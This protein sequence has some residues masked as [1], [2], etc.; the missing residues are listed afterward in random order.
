[1]KSNDQQPPTREKIFARVAGGEISSAEGARLFKDSLVHA[2]GGTFFYHTAWEKTG[3]VARPLDPSHLDKKFLV[4]DQQGDIREALTGILKENKI[5]VDQRLALVTFGSRFKEKGLL[6]Y[7]VRPGQKEDYVKLLIHLEKAGFLPQ[8]LLHG[9]SQAGGPGEEGELSRD[10]Y[11][12]YA[13]IKAQFETG[14]KSLKRLLFLFNEPAGP[15]PRLES[16]S[17]Y[18]RSLRNVD[19]EMFFSLV[20]AVLPGKETRAG[21]PGILSQELA[22]PDGNWDY[23]IRYEQGIRQVRRVKSLEIPQRRES[24]LKPGG[25]YLVTGGGGGLG[26]L[27][28]RY[29]AGKYKAR[30]VLTGRS[31]VDEKCR[32][33]L[34]E[35]EGLGA[36]VTYIPA[37][38]SDEPAMSRVIETAGKQFGRLDGVIHSAG[39]AREN[40]IRDK[41]AAE[42]QD[43]LRPKIQGTI[44]LDRITAGLDLDFFV[45]FSSSSATL[46]DFGQCD[47]AVAN[48][49]MEAFA[50]W[51]EGQRGRNRRRG[52]SLAIGWPMWRAG[53]MHGTP[54]SEALYLKSSGLEYLERETGIEAFENMLA[55]PY[56]QVMVLTGNRERIARFWQPAAASPL[57]ETGQVPGQGRPAPIDRSSIEVRLLSDIRATAAKILRIDP[58]KLECD[59]NLGNYGF[60]SMGLKELAILL[61]KTY[62]VAISPTLFFQQSSLQNFS[63]YLLEEFGGEIERYYTRI[64]DTAGP[65]P[66]TP[67]PHL[68]PRTPETKK[69]LPQKKP[70]IAV[71]GIGCRFPGAAIPGEFWHNL[72]TGRDSISEVPLERWDW[73]DYYGQ[74]KEGEKPVSVSKWAGFIADVDKFDARF[75]NISPREAELMDPQQRIILETVFQTLG[76]AGYRPDDLSGRSVGV[77]I[78]AESND[79]QYLLEGVELSPQMGIGNHHAVLS[80]RISYLL[81]LR[82]AS[83]TINTACSSSLVAVCQAVRAIQSGDCEM[84]IAGGVSLILSPLNMVGTSMIGILSPAGRCYTFDRRANGYVKGEGAGVVFLKALDRAVADHDHIYGVIKG[85]AINHGG[86]AN[87]LT[88]PNSRAQA[89]LVVAA[90]DD[91]DIDPGTVT[92]IETHGTATEL[93]DPVEVEGLKRAFSES[94]GHYPQTVRRTAFCGLGTVKTNIGHLEAASGIAGMIKV[95]LAMKHRILPGILHFRELNPYIDLD[96]SPFYIHT[97]TRHWQTLSDSQGRP[98]PRRSGVSSFGFGGTNAHVVLE[99]YPQPAPQEPAENL[100]QAILL[101]A[102]NEERLKEYAQILL[103]F[104]EAAATPAGEDSPAGISLDDIRRDLTAAA[105]QILHVLPDEIDPGEELPGLG[106]QVLQLSQLAR[107]ID[108]KYHLPVDIERLSAYPTIDSLAQYLYWHRVPAPAVQTHHHPLSLVDI[109]YSLQVGRESMEHRLVFI[110]YNLAD[111]T[112][113]LRRYCRGESAVENVYQGSPKA[114]PPIPGGLLEGE[115]GQDFLLRLARTH[116]IVRLTQLWIS[117][118]DIDWQWL[119]PENKPYR[120]SLPTYPFA[121]TRH[122]VSPPAQSPD[123]TR[124]LYFHNRWQDTGLPAEATAR[125]S[126]IRR[127]LLV[128]ASAE[129][130]PAALNNRCT[131]ENR[132]ELDIVLVK[133]GTGFQDRGNRVYEINPGSADDYVR[134]WTTLKEQDLL[135]IDLVHLWCLDG[136]PDEPAAPWVP[137]REKLEESLQKGIYSIFFLLN[138]AARLNLAHS[139]RIMFFFAG[140]SSPAFPLAEAVSGFSRSLPFIF[141]GL[142]FS[143][144]QL[145]AEGETGPGTTPDLPGII[146]RE[147]FHPSGNGGDHIRYY[148]G[149]RQ[150]QVTASLD[151]QPAGP[152]QLRAGGVYL[153]T[154]GCGGLG[155]LFAHYLAQKYRARLIL[156]GRSGLDEQRREKLRQLE[157]LGGEVF[158]LC[159]DVADEEAMDRGRQEAGEKFG[160]INGIIH[161]AG[162]VDG[163]SL[164]EKNID[165]FTAVLRPKIH[166]TLV[167]DAVSRQEELD[168][169]V[170]FS[171][172]SSILGDFGLGDYAVANRFLD[173]FCQYRNNLVQ[174]KSRWGRTLV[175]NWPLWKDGG[176][177][178]G[179]ESEAYYLENSGL[180]YLEAGDGLLAFETILAGDFP[181]VIAVHGQPSR[182]QELFTGVKKS[183]RKPVAP[184]V[185]ESGR[186]TDGDSL[187]DRI[188][189]DL[190]L[191]AGAILKVNPSELEP[192]ENL[193]AYGFDSI[194]LKE[195]AERLSRAYSVDIPPTLLFKHRT[196]QGLGDYLLNDQQEAISAH[197]RGTAEKSKPGVASGAAQEIAN[198]GRPNPVDTGRIAPPAVYFGSGRQTGQDIAII[199]ISGMFPGSHDVHEF[200]Q[201][202]QA[203]QDLIGEVPIDRWNWRDYYDEANKTGSPAARWGGF[204]PDVDKFDPRF[205]NI[206]YREAEMMDPQQ[207]LLLQLTWKAIEDGGYKVS[208]LSGRPVGVFVGVEKIDYVE[209][210]GANVEFNAQMAI[211]NHYAVLP[212]RISFLLNLRGPSEAINTACSSS[213]TAVNRAVQAIRTGECE[214]AM[215]GG[216]SLILTPMNIVGTSQVGTLSPDGRC[217]TFDQRANGYVK[218]ESIG[219]LFLKPLSRAIPDHDHIYGIIK[220]TAVNH[221]GRANSFTAPN[222]D[223]QA[224]LLVSAYEKS[225][226]DP[227]SVSYIE[228]HGTGTELGDPIEIDGLKQAFSQLAKRRLRSIP[229]TPYCALGTV[230]ANMGHAEAASGVVG[231]IKVLLAMKH[232]ILPG[233]P[234]F[235]TL[236]PY[237]DL[238][239]TPFYIVDKTRPWEKLTDSRGQ[240]LPRRAGVSSFGFGGAN[241]HVILE[242]FA[243]PAPLPGQYRFD[244][245]IF[246]LSARNG[247]RL[248]VYARAMAEFLKHHPKEQLLDIIYTLQTGREP[249]TERL[250]V[251][252]SGSGELGDRLERFC[253]GESDIKDLYCKNRQDSDPAEDFIDGAE[254]KAFIKKIIAEGEMHKLARLWVKGVEI[255]WQM[256]YPGTKPRRLPLPTYPFAPERYWI[257]RLLGQHGRSLFA[258]AF[259]DGDR[260]HPLLDGIDH[261]GTLGEG[262]VYHKT[263]REYEPVV[264]DHTI[265]GQPILPGVCYL[266]MV[267]AAYSRIADGRPFKILDTTWLTPLLIGKETGKINLVIK[268]ENG[269]EKVSFE[270]GSHTDNRYQ[271]HARGWL[272]AAGA[273]RGREQKLP[274]ESIKARCPS[275]VSGELVYREVKQAG[276]NYGPFFQGLEGIDTGEDEALGQFRL[277]APYNQEIHRYILHPAVLDSALHTISGLQKALPGGENP[278]PLLPFSIGEVTIYQ[279]VPAQGYAYV[280]T[281]EGKH[282]FHLAIADTA[283]RICVRLHDV[284]LREMKDGGKTHRPP[285]ID[286]QP[287]Y[288]RARW[289][290][291]ET[292]RKESQAGGQSPWIIYS[293]GS[294]ALA[295]ALA[296]M[297]TF[298]GNRRVTFIELSSRTK[299]RA[300]DHWEIDRHDP[301][302][303]K[304][305]LEKASPVDAIYFL[306]GLDGREI[307]LSVR[308]TFDYTQESGLISL[309]RL[310][311]SLIDHGFTGKKLHI[312]VITGDLFQVIPGQNTRPYDGGIPGLVGSVSKEYAQWEMACLDVGL[313]EIGRPVEKAAADKLA[314]LARMIIAAPV[315]PFDKVTAIRGGQYYVRKIESLVLPPVRPYPFRQ[316][317]VYLILGGAGGIGL[318]FSRYLAETA[319]A[320]LVLVGRK[321]EQELSAEQQM[322]MADIQ[323]CGGEVLYVQ[324]D[325]GDPESMKAAVARARSHFGPI[326]AVIH[327][328]IVLQ[329]G[330]IENMSE[331]TFQAVLAPKTTGSWVLYQAVKDEPLDF[332]LFFSAS[333]SYACGAGQANYA[334]A[335]TFKD[336]FALYL[337]QK[338]TF[339]VK[340]INWGFWGTVGVVASEKYRER[341]AAQGIYAITPNEG[342]QVIQQAMTHD[343]DQL[344]FFKSAGRLLTGLGIDLEHP[345]HLYPGTMPAPVDEPVFT[346]PV[347][348]LAAGLAPIDY[349]RQG[350]FLE[351]VE[352]PLS[353]R[354]EGDRLRETIQEKLLAM[355]A[356][357]VGMNAD[358]IDTGTP[359]SDF[360]IDSIVAVKMVEEINKE[361]NISLKT[362]TF[363]DHPNIGE[364]TRYIIETQGEQ[365]RASLAVE[366]TGTRP[367]DFR[368]DNRPLRLPRSEPSQ[369]QT[370]RDIAVIGIS[371]RFPGAADVNRFWENLSLG[372]SAIQ[373]VPQGR[374]D[375]GEYFSRDTETGNT[376]YCKWG[377]FLEEIG[378]FDAPFFNMPIQEAARTDPQ[379]RLF[380]EESFKAL[381]DAGYGPDSVNGL[382]CGVFVGTAAGDYLNEIEAAGLALDVHSF[383]GNTASLTPTRIS[384]YLNLKGPSLV[385]EAACASSLAA[386]HLAGQSL[387]N[388]ECDMAIAGGVFVTSTAGFFVLASKAGML[389][390]QG[391]CRAFDEQADG[392]VPGEGV[393]AVILKPLASAMM[394]RDHIYG[395]IK[396][397][398]MNQD[399]KTLSLTAPSSRSQASLEAEVYER[400]GIDAGNITYIEA[401]GTG[402]KLGDTIEVEALTQV[403]RQYTSKKQFC[404][405]GSVKTNIGHA[406]T[407]A[408]II[409]LIKVLLAFKY[410]KIPP[411]LNFEHPNSYIDFDN[412][413][414]YVNTTLIDWPLTGNGPRQAAVSAFGFNG[415]NVHLVVEQAPARRPEAGEVGAD[416]DP[417]YLIALSA[418]TEHALE[419]MI[420]GLLN[421]L[422][423]ATGESLGDVA[424]TLLIGRS[425]LPVRIALVVSTRYD[426]EQKLRALA[427]K[428]V[429]ADCFFSQPTEVKNRQAAGLSEQGERL[430]REIHNRRSI[431]AIDYKNHLAALAGLYVKGWSCDW[432]AFYQGQTHYRISMP[433]YPFAR[434][435]CWITGPGQDEENTIPGAGSA[436]RQG[437][438]I[439]ED[440][441]GQN[442]EPDLLEMAAQVFNLPREDLETDRDIGG[443]GFSSRALTE[444]TARIN[445]RYG[446][447]ITPAIFFELDPPTLGELARHLSRAPRHDIARATGRAPARPEP[448]AIIGLG[449]VM[450]QSR[451]LDTFWDHLLAGHDLIGE[452]PPD[453]WDWRTLLDE[454]G[455]SYCRWGGFIDDPDKFDAEFFGISPREA[456]LIDP[457]HRVFLETLW[458]TIEDAGYK[459]SSLSGTQVAVFTGVSTC[460]Y[461]GILLSA[462]VELDAHVATGLPHYMLSNRISYLLNLH[463]P[464]EPIDTACS[465]SLVAVHRA[466]EAIRSGSCQ[467][468]IAGGVNLILTPSGFKALAAGGIL[469]P[470]GRCKTFDRQADGFVRA[471]GAGAVFLKPLRQAEADGDH[472]YAVILA[473]AENHGGRA[474]SLTAPNANAQVD[475][476]V[477]AYTHA[478]IDPATIGY[479]ETHG[480]GTNLGDPV[481]VNGL[482]KAFNELFLRFQKPPAKKPFCGLGSV[483]T[484][485]GHL[486]SAAGIAGLIKVILAMQR[487]KIPATVHFQEMN[488]YLDLA[489]TPFY[490]VDKTIDWAPLLDEGNRPRPRRAGVS[491]FGLG[492]SNAHLI[493]EEYPGDR[494]EAAF[495]AN[496]RQPRI[497]VLSAR[498]E[499]RL[500]A[501]VEQFLDFLDRRSAPVNETTENLFQQTVA[502]LSEM[503]ASILKVG[504]QTIFPD[505]NLVE[506]GFDRISSA[507]FAQRVNE[508][509]PRPSAADSLHEYPSI[510]ALARYLGGQ[511]PDPVSPPIASPMLS[512]ADIAYTL[513]TGREPMPERLAVV[514]SDIPGLRQKLTRYLQADPGIEGLYYR[515]NGVTVGAGTIET[516]IQENDPQRIAQLFVSG[517]DI[518]WSLLYTG[519]KPRR[520]P[521]PGYPFERVRHWVD[522]IAQPKTGYPEHTPVEPGSKPE[523][524]EFTNDMTTIKPDQNQAPQPKMIDIPRVILK[525]KDMALSIAPPP[526][527]GRISLK[528]TEAAAPN[529]AAPVS[530]VKEILAQVLFLDVARIDENKPFIELG[531]DSILVVEFVKKLNDTFRANLQAT[532]VYDYSTVRRLAGFLGG[533][534]GVATPAAADSEPVFPVSA[535][536]YPELTGLPAAPRVSA[537]DVAIIGMSGRFPGA[538][539]TRQYWY[540]LTHGIDSV[541]EVPP[542]RWDVNLFYDPDIH[543]PGK[544]YCKW[545]GFLVD[546]DKFDPLFFNI[547]P[548]EAEL[549]DP[550]QRLFL[551]EA[552]RALEDAGYSAESLD[553]LNCGVFVG[554]MT[555]NEYPSTSIYNSHSILAARISYF[556]NLKGPALSLDTAC[557]SSLVAIHLACKSLI[558]G[559]TDMMLAGGVTLYLTEKPFIGMSRMGGVISPDGKC[560]TFDNSA[561]GFVPAE[562][563]GV[564]VL[565]LLE[566]ALAGNDHIY[567]IIKGSGINQ[568]GRTNGITAPSSESQKELELQVYKTTGID[569]ATISY[570]EA[571]GTGTKLGDPIEITALTEAFRHYTRKQQFCPIGSVKTNI[572]H[573]SA[574]A[575]V[576][577]VIKVLLS[578]AQRQIP[579]SLHFKQE[580]EHIHFKDTPFYVNTTL[581]DWP[582]PVGAPRRAAVSSFGYSGTNAHLIIDEMPDETSRQ[583]P[584]ARE[585]YPYYLIAMSARNREILNQKISDLSTWCLQQGMAHSLADIAYTLGFGRSHFSCRLALV[586]DSVPA[587]ENALRLLAE[588]EIPGHCYF[589]GAG[590]VPLSAESGPGKIDH[591]HPGMQTPGPMPPDVYRDKLGELAR[592]YVQGHTPD[593]QALYRGQAVGRIPLPGYPFEK[594]RYWVP[595]EYFSQAPAMAAAQPAPFQAPAIAFHRQEI[596]QDFIEKHIQQDLVFFIGDILKV[597]EKDID[598]D[599]NMLTYGFD[600]ITFT[601]YINRINK[602]YGIKF[603][604]EIFFDLGTPTIRSLGTTLYRQYKDNLEIYFRGAVPPA[605]A[606]PAAIVPQSPGAEP[607][608]KPGHQQG[609]IAIIGIDALIPGTHSLEDFWKCLA[610][611]RELITD[612]PEERWKLWGKT[613]KG[614]RTGALMADVDAFDAAFFGISDDQAARLD[615]QQ[616]IFLET[617]WRA[618]EDAGYRAATLDSSKTGVFVGLSPSGYNGKDRENSITQ[619]ANRVSRLLNLRGPSEVFSSADSSF[620]AALHRA[621]QALENGSC[622]LAI[623]GGIHLVLDIDAWDS[624]AGKAGTGIPAEAA[625]AVVLKPLDKAS[626]DRD[627][628]Y[629]LIKG[630][631]VDYAGWSDA[632]SIPDAGILAD[633]LFDMYEDLGLDPGTL[634]Y[635]EIYGPDPGARI[636][637]SPGTKAL[638]AAFTRLFNREHPA[639]S[640][641][642]PCGLGTAAPHLGHLQAAAG[643]VSLIRVLLSL[644]HKTLVQTIKKDG[645]NAS[646]GKLSTP[647]YLVGETKAWECLL[648]KENRPLPRRAAIDTTSYGGT[649]AHL[650]LEEYPAPG[651]GTET[652]QP[653]KDQQDYI[654]VLSA[655]NEKGLRERAQNLE[656][657]L[658]RSLHSHPGPTLPAAKNVDFRQQFEDDVLKLSAENLTTGEKGYEHAGIG[659]F[660]KRFNETF[661]LD[662]PAEDFLRH[663]SVGAFIKHLR[664]KYRSELENYYRAKSMEEAH[665]PDINLEDIAY[666]LQVGRQEM[667]ERLALVVTGSR[668]LV[669]KLGAFGRGQEGVENMYRGNASTSGHLSRALFDGEEREVFIESI[670][671]NRKFAK[672]GYCW[673]LG[674]Q[675]DWQLL[676]RHCSPRRLALP[677][678]PFERRKYWH[679][680]GPEGPEKNRDVE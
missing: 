351:P 32:A 483:K 306:A 416:I 461:L 25:T 90:F 653:G 88:A 395:V 651:T 507:L 207:R 192:H 591:R 450:P 418:R 647:F 622:Q 642:P 322:K 339:P 491:S 637:G 39:I 532:K 14:I 125:E 494:Q 537:G 2:T 390:R 442:L 279:P 170:M 46:G 434:L 58:Q 372:A 369:R 381:E 480:T 95:L 97:E 101:S 261:Q 338:V 515:K 258:Y 407:A 183:T 204:L 108:E 1:M 266:E 581:A 203:G 352:E 475:L 312:R 247:E 546:V 295:Q 114:G 567:G 229:A 348:D 565:K 307:D 425:H 8:V 391:I 426:L 289:E 107:H 535:G 558:A 602:K 116:D 214:M 246:V 539:N 540:N 574:A 506:C 573:T 197:Y 439:S 222:P 131:G 264:R 421:W 344:I 417:F 638:D 672:L 616:R 294:R 250:A 121:R 543:A 589:T 413:P 155:F 105:A 522:G 4:F 330:I 680:P 454:N 550:Q 354:P 584:T 120:V 472:I 188:Q 512:L 649:H 102:R 467:A 359:F 308:S 276:M 328:A 42:F 254:G 347:N 549:L 61:G 404:A 136:S 309:F 275:H 263:F 174:E 315:P 302:A 396:S 362:T 109:A 129:D 172:L 529:L 440:H 456:R 394:D 168:F 424:Y 350:V 340:I 83:E 135:P 519:K 287:S 604:L 435:N 158:Y 378:A 497:I 386:V 420:T 659:A 304:N 583:E 139:E 51:R 485:I 154:G 285:H 319:K 132:E 441:G 175:I 161:A 74:T 321:P 100:A 209:L 481:E 200:W 364:L 334:A 205:F 286:S 367:S 667:A 297:Y 157:Q 534:A 117:G 201:N 23:D 256:L 52:R 146:I 82:G 327:S 147:L 267:Q 626:L 511:S 118:A 449:G 248:K 566:K 557:S 9:W 281:G 620:P 235:Q 493:V 164:S 422:P 419:Q 134:L 251:V 29:L 217:K 576:A 392:F 504:S 509:Y 585:A 343:L 556:L 260:I 552:W 613:K 458:K 530:R 473:S 106:L 111:L 262:I 349:Q 186:G 318:E 89:D 33:Y 75:F 433:T 141:P 569:P 271:V 303:F 531:L 528:K 298:S 635:I 252:I 673:T 617:A 658:K 357:A 353:K 640:D 84:A 577:S 430:I 282:R 431:P 44:V 628:I 405:I 17:A 607:R 313:A 181:Q 603:T 55:S 459:P 598:L 671:K 48:R 384:Y 618:L 621:V 650:V 187:I 290:I 173:S 479:I 587:L 167:L 265:G 568:D 87:S 643:L 144:I 13:M 460:D 488:P 35:L 452:A 646:A 564:V 36:Q 237:I 368:V 269:R 554:V 78:G 586:V 612:I 162:V 34:Q 259:G 609:P 608:M 140:T 326:N 601:E 310:F 400:A 190:K 648:D 370:D 445:E 93:G 156:T 636:L 560:K 112:D 679:S 363:F 85:T 411:S 236:N 62:K 437:P 3:P 453:R 588:G 382:R 184:V 501:S 18:G 561:D 389:S 69:E 355:L 225:A 86:K 31:P 514:V 142:T 202:L 443:Y 398:G 67:A 468:A 15:D 346:A 555:S 361:F 677:T 182:V 143:T 219:V 171:S 152:S 605:P 28:A 448:I 490:I 249:M 489:D 80:N 291:F 513:Q 545:G 253:R 655:K 288:F 320:R 243:G 305:C 375:I 230:K 403:F 194:T 502:D 412:S 228:A 594:E 623:V 536:I 487:K 675:I 212:N 240:A 333:Q 324:A 185:Q 137:G 541:T 393:G 570:V 68:P 652:A 206:S 551:Q 244:S 477:D 24:L 231:I 444:L 527:P 451:D 596:N 6:T 518:D 76:D 582:V 323:T 644:K 457:Q 516:A 615:P 387:I 193:G 124:T 666:T 195:F 599:G 65:A 486:E 660:V 233:N 345:V 191:M 208:D 674:V 503:A 257:P 600:S 383:L 53:G 40:Q 438:A 21:W 45:M 255:D 544:T 133:P 12:L 59:E 70:D 406:A 669:Q 462:T 500:R 63:Q 436:S 371:G 678:Y 505:E 16:L 482:K 216:A 272:S 423:T 81:N 374:W 113:K 176:M 365:I 57:P 593:W 274:V 547:S 331:E 366:D 465:S 160:P 432:T 578:L 542:E 619:V 128:L 38:V 11:S 630:T 610:D 397:S 597:K 127:R 232:Q 341:M 645:W 633:N 26:L 337:K 49:F 495:A 245:F 664:K 563:V 379:Q 455:D 427:E 356:A 239:G 19:A 177:R 548:A 130:L 283:G 665:H 474:Q 464:S 293:P 470:N 5:A 166:G 211:G 525:D 592:L 520:I 311:K 221:G 538:E 273:D 360:G 148:Q 498:K 104:L 7:E 402:T 300:A 43:T 639:M 399:G 523:K 508:K 30:L 126:A 634:S 627:H 72:R 292:C 213:M 301:Q 150:S 429:P 66:K 223:A 296:D 553:N 145:A 47:Y 526:G 299:R 336:A 401:H 676:Y 151:L 179:Q 96:Q 409:S 153:I 533:L 572:G 625:G 277:P 668:E 227:E 218:A 524:K 22:C 447:G 632:L 496:D 280:K 471:E 373:E 579:P 226:I 242:E 654:I 180:A 499:D 316:G 614:T 590:E 408:G 663:H 656:E 388:G 463:G 178:M 284:V 624:Q 115:A 138:T 484:N 94:A 165:D 492:G 571:H 110:V 198:G 358:E 611:G 122:W 661:G 657:F 238:T 54:D 332:M 189:Q 37:D 169:F 575:G 241:A 163:Q 50:D 580:N 466:V 335:C 317:G 377:G 99:E 670:I 56:T 380:L 220:A 342:M 325:A 77:F 510:Q 559:E 606:P 210:L 98:I 71:I 385:V 91:A 92:Y 595:Q 119:Y 20:R 476:L 79:Y 103:A 629:A 446:A 469:S 478:G 10:V 60:D 414:F 329:D 123:L 641:R 41:E 234:H 215:A 415:A 662:I 410:G 517:V 428:K 196:I 73:R 27:F 149:Q 159:A 521:L 270:I 268:R 631:A 562:G 314:G 376:T 224:E 278:K 199:G 64:E